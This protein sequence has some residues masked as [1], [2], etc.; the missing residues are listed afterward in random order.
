MGHIISLHEDPHREVEALLPWY[1]AGALDAE[2]HTRVEAHLGD[3][4]ACRAELA[5]ERRL[6]SE[7]A[8]LP[9]DVEHGW[10]RLHRRLDMRPRRAESFGWLA[11]AG[12][13]WRAGPTWLGWALAA[14]AGLIAAFGLLVAPVSPPA[15]SAPYHALSAAAP[16]A[17]GNVVVIFRP[18]TSERILRETLR[19]SHARL[20]DGPTASDAYVLAVPAA[21]RASILTSLRA[22]SDIILAEPINAGGPP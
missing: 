14:Q 18:E 5:Y 20:V 16:S 1:L 10:A 8:A 6:K 11:R 9:T 4:Q 13:A 12:R 17:P 2:E 22:R 3:C 15:P 19:A 7:V 21:A